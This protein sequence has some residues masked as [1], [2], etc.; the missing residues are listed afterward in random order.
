M[1]AIV[2]GK[3]SFFEELPTTPAALSSSKRFRCS[4]TS[5]NRFSP[6]RNYNP[7][8]SPSSSSLINF[9]QSDN[10]GPSSPALAH[11]QT[12]FPEMDIKLLEKALNESEN[13]DSAIKSLN[14]LRLGSV[15]R[16][17]TSA[18]VNTDLPTQGIEYNGENVVPSED[19]RVNNLPKNG[20]EWVE[21]F[22]NEMT[23]ASDIDDAKARASRVLEVLEK[24]IRTQAGAAAADDLHKENMML[25]KQMEDLIHENYILKRAVAIQNERLKEADNKNQELQSLKQLVS[26]YQER[27]STLEVNNFTLAMHLK[28]AQQ[29]SPIPGRFHPDVF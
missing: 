26:Q 6:P 28:Q 21:L 16:N 12:M 17:S 1:S 20:A 15:E 29:T 18:A 25:K 14:E 8:S 4:S 22:V 9:Q 23:S 27:V 19:L 5:P 10:N 2:C 11:L 3:R 13:L 24:S 7:F